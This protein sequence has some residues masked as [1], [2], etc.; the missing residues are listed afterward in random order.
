[1]NTLIDTLNAARSIINAA[2][3]ASAIK[4][5]D[6]LKIALFDRLVD[7][8]LNPNDWN[9]L[10][11]NNNL[12]IKDKADNTIFNRD[13]AAHILKYWVNKSNKLPI[14]EL[15]MEEVGVGEWTMEDDLEA[16]NQYISAC[17]AAIAN[18]ALDVENK[19]DLLETYTQL[20]TM[21]IDMETLLDEKEDVPEILPE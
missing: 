12:S 13:E 19:L 7:D 2:L 18:R 6:E 20:V 3:N 9:C 21:K 5:I 14:I 15:D 10:I 11:V 16:V 1:M 4:S 17:K 8:N